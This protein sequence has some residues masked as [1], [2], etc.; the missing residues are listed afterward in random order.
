M[1]NYVYF[2]HSLRDVLALREHVKQCF[3]IPALRFAPLILANERH[4]DGSMLIILAVENP[5]WLALETGNVDPLVGGISALEVEVAV[6][7][8]TVCA[9]P[10]RSLPRRQPATFCAFPCH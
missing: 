5:S 2:K 9:E 4:D 7:A 6:G 10:I 3:Q 8:A 1:T